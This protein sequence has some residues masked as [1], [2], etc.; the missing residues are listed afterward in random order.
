MDSLWNAIDYFID[1]FSNLITSL[2]PPDAHAN[3]F[4]LSPKQHVGDIILAHIFFGLC[5]YFGLS[6]EEE[7]RKTNNGNNKKTVSKPLHPVEHIFRVVLTLNIILQLIYK[8]LRGWRILG[9]M[10]QPC[11]ITTCLYLFCLYTKN[12]HLGNRV[13]QLS[14]H[15]M[16]FTALALLVPDL[17]QLHLP[18]EQS[19][20]WIQHWA[21]LGAP[22][23]MLLISRRYHPMAPSFKNSLLAIGL[24]GLFHFDVQLPLAFLTGVNINYMLWPPPGVPSWMSN[25]MYRYYLCFALVLLAFLCGYFFVGLVHSSLPSPSKTSSSKKSPKVE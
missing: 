7:K 10:L 17:N 15:Y 21:L 22:L 18:F 3:H 1:P 16:F 5:A 8:T 23:V 13:F 12:H 20:F 14:I 4:F 11:H 24:G 6:S 2:Q 25:W 9:Y 19:N